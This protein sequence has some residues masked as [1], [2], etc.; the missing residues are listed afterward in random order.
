M[1][2]WFNIKKGGTIMGSLVL[3]NGAFNRSSP[4]CGLMG[5]LVRVVVC[6]SCKQ[7]GVV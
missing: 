3:F 2:G 1:A 7:F 4:A 6:D 5:Q